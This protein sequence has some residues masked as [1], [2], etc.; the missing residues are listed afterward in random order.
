M[1]GLARGL[2]PGLGQLVFRPLRRVPVRFLVQLL[3]AHVCV[4]GA[5]AGP[6]CRGL[7]WGVYLDGGQSG[8]TVHACAL[9]YHTLSPHK[10][11]VLAALRGPL[12]H[13]KRRVRRA[14]YECVN[15]WHLL[16][17]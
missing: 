6:W 9:P 1:F 4:H 17:A 10:R 5:P 16:K 2:G 12:D 15:R 3:R 11:Q 13:H 7:V 8:V 14:A